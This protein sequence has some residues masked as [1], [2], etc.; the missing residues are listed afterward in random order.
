M[1]ARRWIA[2]ALVAVVGVLGLAACGG[3]G[4]DNATLPGEVKATKF[5]RFDPDHFN[6]RFNRDTSFTFKNTDSREHNFTLS[7]VFTDVDNFV[8]VDVPAGQSKEVRF[9][10]KDRPKA[11]YLTFYCRFHQNQGMSGKIKLT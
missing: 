11:G 10:V 6:V 8:S 3:G 4:G 1:G 5:L 9:T 2:S 7:Y